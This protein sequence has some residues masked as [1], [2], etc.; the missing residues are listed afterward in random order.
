MSVLAS[1][2]IARAWASDA[3]FT[4]Q[5]KAHPPLLVRVKTSNSLS[6]VG[7]STL[8]TDF[9]GFLHR[10][11]VVLFHDCRKVVSLVSSVNLD[12]LKSTKYVACVTLTY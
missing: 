6:F 5:L 11:S 10:F 1:K 12:Y 9:E 3:A 2:T 4:E 8:L 7:F